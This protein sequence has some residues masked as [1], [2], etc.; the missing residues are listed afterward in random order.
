[1]SENKNGIVVK[2][3]GLYYTVNAD[4]ESRNCTLRGRIRQ[5]EENKTITNPVAV[6]DYVNF[7]IQDDGSGVIENIHDRTNIFSRKEKGRNSKEDII[8][9]NC[10]LIVVMQSFRQPRLNL[11]F[12]DRISVRGKMQG[13]PV[14]V[15]VNKSDLAK[16]NEKMGVLD[17]YRNAGNDIVFVSAVTSHGLKDLYRYLEGNVSILVGFSGVGKSSILNGIFPSLDLRVKEVSSRTG[18]GRHTTTNVE[19]IKVDDNTAIIDTP[20]M[21]EFGLMDMEPHIV[22]NYFYEFAEYADKC[23]FMPCTHDHEPGCE[24]KRLVE[25]G[26]IST[27]RYVSYL[28]ILHSLQ[29]YF[30]N[31]YS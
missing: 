17:Y 7:T 8:A 5:S 12:V 3:M 4:G 29:E 2:V 24:I 19:M 22:G 25:Q 21:R 30:D 15:C 27:E 26:T 14:L 20:G 6:G 13:I 1:M 9:A 16:E 10:D 11:R 28:N 18:K 31:M 23:S